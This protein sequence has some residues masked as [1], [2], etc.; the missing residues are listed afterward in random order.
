[1]QWVAPVGRHYSGLPLSPWAWACGCQCH[2]LPSCNHRW[3]TWSS[4]PDWFSCPSSCEWRK[5]Y[6]KNNTSC[7]PSS[8]NVAL[9]NARQILKKRKVKRH[10][11]LLLRAA[12]R[13]KWGYVLREGPGFL[14]THTNS[15]MSCQSNLVLFT[16]RQP[17]QLQSV[18]KTIFWHILDFEVIL[19]LSCWI[20]IFPVCILRYMF[21]LD[22]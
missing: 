9:T 21:W 4:F 20:S 13:G 3:H 2:T 14:N 11:T 15:T 1:M 16:L 7:R 18:T 19:P 17:P 6:R 12:E 5:Q 8:G 22:L 10:T